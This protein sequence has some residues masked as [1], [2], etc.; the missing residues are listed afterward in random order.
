MTA[1]VTA[2][3]LITLALG[4]LATIAIWARGISRARGL[5]VLAFLLAS[6][7]AAAALAMAL[8]W[9]IPLIEGITVAEGKHPV[10][11]A[12]MIPDVGIYV[13]LDI[14]DGAPRYFSLPWS[15]PAADKLQQ[16]MDEG[17]E[18][19]G[20]GIDVPPFEFSWDRREPK[21]YAN[22][23]PKVLPDK[24]ADAAPV[25]NQEF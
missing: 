9:P 1:T 24:P 5:A 3:L 4:G 19:D 22:P 8:G 7:V 25:F 15:P 14:G 6:P 13:L 17:A 20:T 16:A 10:L 11:G 12:K 21:F 2:W 18:G 23:Q